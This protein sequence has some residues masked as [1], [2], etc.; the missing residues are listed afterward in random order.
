MKRDIDHISKLFLKELRE[1]LSPSEK[2]ELEAL[3]KRDPALREFHEENIKNTDGLTDGVKFIL[4]KF[5]VP[6]GEKDQQ[7]AFDKIFNKYISEEK[8]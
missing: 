8:I 2:I 6:T 7:I 1:E 4:S 5:T 3:L